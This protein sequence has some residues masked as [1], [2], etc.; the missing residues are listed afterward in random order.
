MSLESILRPL[1][2]TIALG[3]I[4]L[5]AAH[6]PAPA[7]SRYTTAGVLSVVFIGWEAVAQYLGAANTYLATIENPPAVPTILLGLLIPL[8]VAAI[9]LWRVGQHRK[10]GLR[11][12][13]AFGSWRLRSIA[14]RAA[15]SSCFGL[16]GRL[17]WQFAL[18]AGIGDVTTGIV[19]V[20]VAARLARNAIGAYRATY[21]WCLFGIADL[22]VAITMG[23]MTSP[24][25]AHLLAFDA[26]NLLVTA[27]PLVMIPTFAVP[28][29]LML[30]GLVL[31]RL[32]LRRG[33]ATTGPAGGSMR[34]L[35]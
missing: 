10:A 7:K 25:R 21:A 6:M 18:P 17:P 12:P 28:L 16:N 14:S 11:D 4:W 33:A 15:F 24:G 2:M 22:V 20:V 31:L 1:V 30:H 27:Y 32:R 3:L 23:A 35:A 13:G 19:A 5:G 26:P 8:A 34:P 9:G 29:A